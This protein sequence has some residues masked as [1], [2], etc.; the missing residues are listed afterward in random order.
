M[1]NSTCNGSYCPNFH[2][3]S[4]DAC[5]LTVKS[6]IVIEHECF[7]TLMTALSV[8]DV[9]RATPLKQSTLSATQNSQRF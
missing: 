5:E 7:E 2:P 4:I 1:F 8:R 9:R 6:S 3:F